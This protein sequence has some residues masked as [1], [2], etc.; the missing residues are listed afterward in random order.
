MIRY[1]TDLICNTLL[2]GTA[3]RHARRSYCF[4]GG[5]YT[6][7]PYQL[8]NHG[9]PPAIVADNILGLIEARYATARTRPPPHFEAWIYETFGRGIADHFMIPYNRRQWAWDLRDMHYDWIADRVPMPDLGDVVRGALETRTEKYGPNQEFWYPER[10]GIQ[11]VPRALLRRVPPARVA[12]RSTVVEVNAARRQLRLSD[13]RR[14]AY[15]RLI[16]TIPLPALVQLM[17]ESVPADVRHS[18]AALKSNTVHTV[19]I[20]LDGGELPMNEG[21]HWVYFPEDQSGIFHRISFPGHFSPSMVPP[22]C[23]S[24]QAE[25]SASA[26]RPCD[27]SRLVEQTLA[28]LVMAGILTEK[29]VRPVDE[30]GRVRVAEVVTLDP[31]YVIYNV[32]HRANTS[33][34]HAYLS[35]LG[36]R[37]AGRFGEWEYLN[38]DQVILRGRA[39]AEEAVA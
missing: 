6:E 24:I 28:G 19:N 11:A 32:A 23:S 14:I 31:A 8:N 34:I 30:G 13:G 16:S 25:I 37:S 22:G 27:R 38:M 35:T 2:E 20:G 9:L 21:M 1:A 10:G 17:G 18:G 7:Y 12:F 5:V 26:Y 3:R 15:Q 33:R 29:E 4:T 39:A 36:I